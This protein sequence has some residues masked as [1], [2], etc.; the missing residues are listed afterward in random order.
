MHV[1]SE[2]R[3]AV[4]RT[5]AFGPVWLGD[6]GARLGYQVITFLV[7]LLVV[8]ELGGTGAQVGL[9]SGSQT[10]PTIALSLLVGVWIARL[11]LKLVLVVANGA[12][13]GALLLFAALYVVGRLGFAELL[14]LA[15]AIG[16]V[17]VFYDIA[18]QVAVPQVL[19]GEHLV[20]ANGLLQASTSAAQMAGP[21]AAGLL[22]DEFGFAVAATATATLLA[23]SAAAYSAARL[24][25]A[26]PAPDRGAQPTVREGLAYTWR[27]RPIR[28]LC[29]QSAL[30]NLHEQAFI[31]IFLLFGVRELGLSGSLVGT[32]IGSGSVGVVVGALA[33]GRLGGR[34][35]L[36][37]TLTAAII[38]ASVGLLLVPAAVLTNGPVITLSIGFVVNGAALALYN[39]LA[40]TVRQELPPRRLLGSVTASYRIAVFG[41][42]PIGSLLGGL[43]ADLVGPGAALWAVVC[44]L[45]AT[46]LFLLT[47]PL[48]GARR[49]EDA[50]RLA[51]AHAE[52]AVLTT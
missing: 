12:R 27:T 51:A 47:S 18:V 31:T 3:V 35:H 38:T 6:L 24:T 50:K 37:R 15:L 49:M 17:T 16:C 45:A 14:L 20:S 5:R 7:P 8:S 9:V 26:A 48:A 30:F 42:V 34:V 36:G 21:A 40:I 2:Q 43:L 32:L 4:L 11:R 25:P 13:A 29:I 39:V 28:D 46:S 23:G 52:G 33:A 44:S 41:T 1:S 22:T 19:S 10:V